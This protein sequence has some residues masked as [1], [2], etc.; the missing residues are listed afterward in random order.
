M[1]FFL[2]TFLLP[3]PRPPPRKTK[4]LIDTSASGTSPRRPGTT[5][6]PTTRSAGPRSATAGR[7][8]GCTLHAG[9]RAR[10]RWPWE[11]GGGRR[12]RRRRL[13]AALQELFFFSN[14]SNLIV[15]FMDVFFFAFF[16]V[17]YKALCGNRRK[18]TRE[19]FFLFSLFLSFFPSSMSSAPHQASLREASPR[20][21]SSRSGTSLARPG[22]SSRACGGLGRR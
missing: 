20:C 13:V 11:G 15:D 19:R 12:R 3:R 5:S 14:S 16:Q 2:L 10:R 4:L 8:L 17:I 21:T 18:R 6:P 1:M 7:W 22:S 9:P